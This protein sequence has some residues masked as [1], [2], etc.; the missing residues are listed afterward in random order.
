MGAAPITHRWN[1]MSLTA[2]LVLAATTTVPSQVAA[3]PSR[4]TLASTERPASETFETAAGSMWPDEAISQYAAEYGVSLAD[5]RVN[6]ELQDTIGQ[7][8]A[9]AHLL[10][11]T[12]LV[13]TQLHH[14]GDP[15]LEVNLSKDAPRKVVEG[16]EALDPRV[17]VT[18]SSNEPY[19]F[20]SE[21]LKA[22]AS[23][24]TPFVLEGV[25]KS[26]LGRNVIAD[27]SI[28]EGT[29]SEVTPE[30][31]GDLALS[32]GV[33]AGNLLVEISLFAAGDSNSGGLPL[34][35]CTS[36]F[37]VRNSA[38]TRGL[39]TAGHCGNSQSYSIYG[40]PGSYAM[41]YQAEL[42]S[43]SADLQWHTISGTV[44]ARYYGP[45]TSSTVTVTSSTSQS[46][47][48]G[49]YVCSRGKTSG[50]RC[51]TINS[52]S[53]T[54]TWTDA[55]PGTTCSATWVR[56]GA[57][58]QG[59]DSGGPW[60]ASGSAYGVHKGGSTSFSVFTSGNYFGSLGV[61]IVYG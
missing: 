60:A 51:G 22:A 2:T 29:P 27:I 32:L 3:A 42:R 56:V 18:E 36:G 48:L 38:G 5:A 28:P 55:C 47:Q 23:S 61:A 45:S 8:E 35:T 58:S 6:L 37:A 20:T 31:I 46:Q 41:T 11:A 34:S 12:W 7:I 13:G 39:L 4:V 30:M 16:I 10:G 57:S 21:Q 1:W 40:F 53:Y 43:A 25:G 44:Y 49:D 9:D 52:I 14:G 26:D 50:Y 19:R 33:P 54:P 24:V 17:I 59:G 15:W